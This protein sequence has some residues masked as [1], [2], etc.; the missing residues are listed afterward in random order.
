MDADRNYISDQECR[1]LAELVKYSGLT[2]TRLFDSAALKDWVDEA[3]VRK[4]FYGQNKKTV[5]EMFDHV[6]RTQLLLSLPD[7]SL[8][9]GERGATS[10][11]NTRVLP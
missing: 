6:K 7:R 10:C 11:E 8:L 1:G 9:R 4:T 5:R 3:R 2:F